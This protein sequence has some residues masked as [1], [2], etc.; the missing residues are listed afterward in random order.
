MRRAELIRLMRTTAQARLEGV[1]S[2]PYTQLA[3]LP[4]YSGENID[5]TKARL[6]TY[7]DDI[8][9]GRLRVVVQGVVQGWLGFSCVEAWGFTVDPDGSVTSLPEEALWDFT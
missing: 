7:R 2:R 8:G 4:P 1:R 5:A 6:S 3:E 9:A